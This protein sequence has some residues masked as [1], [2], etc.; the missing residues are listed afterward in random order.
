MTTQTTQSTQTT[1]IDAPVTVPV[2]ALLLHHHMGDYTVHRFLAEVLTEMKA[3]KAI[4]DFEVLATSRTEWMEVGLF[5][6]DLHGVVQQTMTWQQSKDAVEAYMTSLFHDEVL[7][8]GLYG[9]PTA[10]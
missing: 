5:S 6:V 3:E 4:E 8:Q 7:V 9:K 2:R 1:P 10:A